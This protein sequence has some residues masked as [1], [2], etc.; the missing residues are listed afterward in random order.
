MPTPR[1]SPPAYWPTNGWL[2]STP[3]QEGMDSTALASILDGIRKQGM[4]LHSLLVVRHGY[5]VTEVYFYP[6]RPDVPHEQWSITKAVTASVAGIA[7]AEG[8]LRLDQQVLPFF[9][10]RIIGNYD[11]RKLQITIEN[12]LTMTAGLSWDESSKAYGNPANDETR[13]MG[14]PDWL[15]FVLDRPIADDPGS[16]FTYNSGAVH[17][18]SAII[19]RATGLT[20]LDY[21]T[22]R[23]FGPLGISGVTWPS[24]LQGITIGGVDLRLTPRDM[25]KIGYL[26]LQNGQWEGRQILPAWFVA[27]AT[28]K[29]SG[30]GPGFGYQWRPTSFGGFE[31]VGWGSQLIGVVPS[32]DLEV[33][34]TGGVAPGEPGREEDLFRAISQGAVK[35]DGPLAPNPGAAARLASLTA[36]AL[37]PDPQP[38]PALPPLAG[39][40]SGITFALSDEP[41]GMQSVALSFGSGAATLALGIDGK[42]VNLD[43]GLDNTYRFTQLGAESAAAR[44]RWQNDETFV[45]EVLQLGRADSL[46]YNLTFTAGRVDGHI[47]SHIQDEHVQIHGQAP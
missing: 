27:A 39:R 8:R 23:L 32:Q 22:R 17:L 18:L 26:Y 28:R 36:T 3:E 5:I 2:K 45:V 12:L 13:M 4:H 9:A 25:A 40:I 30:D 24:D 41:D 46:T 7:I 14:S 15:Q 31:A 20:T 33:V 11:P 10:D 35:S 37:Q 47:D 44:G 16:K 6:N 34:I 29:H 43:V 38:V 42:I 19:Q 1:V 21:A